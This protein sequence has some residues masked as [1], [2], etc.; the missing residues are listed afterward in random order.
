MLW[1]EIG[2]NQEALNDFQQSLKI[3]PFNY[4]VLL[5]RG[6]VYYSMKQYDL[7]L[8]DFTQ[9]LELEPSSTEASQYI[10][11]ARSKLP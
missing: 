2:R 7:A 6:A 8:K 10:K 11:S 3:E 9:A 1:M 5:K 4:Q